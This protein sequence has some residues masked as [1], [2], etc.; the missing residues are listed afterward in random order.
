MHDAHDYT[1]ILKV[2]DDRKELL[3]ISFGLAG[4]LPVVG[5]WNG[6]G[7]SDIAIYRI[8]DGKGTFF[9]DWNLG[10]DPEQ[11]IPFGVTDCIPLSSMATHTNP[12]LL[13]N[14]SK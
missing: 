10:H 2:S 3:K 9:L 14:K 6:D 8:V 11:L 1:W 4:D 12:V 13:P 7:K 5:D